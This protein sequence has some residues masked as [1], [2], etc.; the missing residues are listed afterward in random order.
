MEAAD[1]MTGF[2]LRGIM[3]T[4]FQLEKAFFYADHLFR[5]IPGGSRRG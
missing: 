1:Q 2:P 4:P 5:Y 3:N